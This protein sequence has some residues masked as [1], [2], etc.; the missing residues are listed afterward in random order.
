MAWTNRTK[1]VPTTTR[2]RILNRDSHTCQNCGTTTGPLEVDHINN[3]RGPG[4][5]NDHNLQ[6]LCTTCHTTKTRTE[7]QAGLQRRAARR[8]LPATPHPGLS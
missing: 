2:K 4:Y 6:T 7:Q 1:H 5:N 8:R 3:T